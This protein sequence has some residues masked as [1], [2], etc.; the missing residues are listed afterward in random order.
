MTKCYISKSVKNGKLLPAEK[1]GNILVVG[2]ESKR[3]LLSFISADSFMK[4][5]LYIYMTL[6]L[7]FLLCLN[8]KFSD[9]KRTSFIYYEFSIAI[10]VFLQDFKGVCITRMGTDKNCSTYTIIQC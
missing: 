9:F 5:N 2:K 1:F 7:K 4:N 3:K 8:G 6:G 10:N